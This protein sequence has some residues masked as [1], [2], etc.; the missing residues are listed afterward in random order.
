[1]TTPRI[2]IIGIGLIGGSVALRLKSQGVSLYLDDSDPVTQVAARQQGFTAVG[3]WTSWIHSVDW[4]V[5]AV[6]LKHVA[7][8]MESVAP[9][10][11]SSGWLIE[12][13]SVKTPL[14]PALRSAARHVQV[15]SLHFMAGRERE[16]FAA[17]R[18]DLFQGC[19]AALVEGAWGVPG[20]EWLDWWR[21]NLGV[22]RFTHHCAAEHDAMMAWISQLP[23][24]A[25][26][27]VREV[28]EQ[29]HPD[30][31]ELT[32]PGFRDTTRVGRQAWESVAPSFSAN[33]EELTRALLALESTLRSWREDLD[34]SNSCWQPVREG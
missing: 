27:A 9:H 10:L 18:A 15:A 20:P 34:R 33:P 17:A 24:L 16:G 1:M 19:P 21:V 5:L 6:P 3:P 13:S 32:G 22:A 30:A 26:R 14:I 23:Y 4:L 2:G 8:L 25:S 29:N 12:L 31:L 7:R 28:V 11:P